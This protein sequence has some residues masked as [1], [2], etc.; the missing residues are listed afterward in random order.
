MPILTDDPITVSSRVLG[1]NSIGEIQITLGLLSDR[2]TL[3]DSAGQFWCLTDSGL[4]KRLT[5]GKDDGSG[6]EVTGPR[7][8]TGRG[9]PSTSIGGVNDY[10]LDFNPA[11]SELPYSEYMKDAAQQ[12][13]SLMVYGPKSAL[14]GGTWLTGY[15]SR[16]YGSDWYGRFVGV[17]GV[18]EEITLLGWDF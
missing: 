7:V 11:A 16:A 3:P 17:P 10:Y 5:R 18:G 14:R 13:F 4:T 6:W 8:F 1:F 2:P 12:G 9:F 15:P